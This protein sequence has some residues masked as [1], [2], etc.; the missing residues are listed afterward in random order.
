MAVVEK[1]RTNKALHK[2]EIMVIKTIPCVLSLCYIANTILSY[3]GVEVEI[4]SMLG[5]LSLIP[6][7]FILISSFVFGFCKYH[8]MMIYYIGISEGLAWIDHYH[9]IPI[10]NNTYFMILFILIGVFVFL[11]IYFKVK[12]I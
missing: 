9:E 6:F 12:N 1:S 2:T 5:G 3:C 7:I 8:R 10:S 11:T 4:F